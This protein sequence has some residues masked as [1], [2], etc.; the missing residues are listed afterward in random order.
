MRDFVSNKFDY[1]LDF[2]PNMHFTS[3]M[4]F[5][6]FLVLI[7]ALLNWNLYTKR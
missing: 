4:V 7:F 1:K 3:I 6:S 5:T 2:D